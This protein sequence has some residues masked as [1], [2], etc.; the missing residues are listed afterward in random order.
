MLK[1]SRGIELTGETM[2]P[3]TNRELRPTTPTNRRKLVKPLLWKNVRSSS[4]V[5]SRQSK[6][7]T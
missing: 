6:I 3:R 7:T 2:T 4:D 5:F 1:R